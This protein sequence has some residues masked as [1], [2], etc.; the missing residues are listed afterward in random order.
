MQ[1]FKSDYMEGAHPL[2]L[3]RLC[4][5]NMEKTSGYGTDEYCASARRKIAE[6]CGCP[7]AE[8]HFMVG[9]T[10]TNATVITA[11]LRPYEGVVAAETGH[12]NQHEAGAV[13]AGG[14]KVLA[15][16]HHEGKLDAAEVD[17]YVTAFY[18]DSS[19]DHMVSPGMVYISHPTEYGTLYT[20]DELKDLSAVCRKHKIPLFLDGARLGYGLTARDTDVTLKDIASLCDIFYIGGTK[21]GA[22]F[23]EAVVIPQPGLI[24]QFDTIVKQRGVLLAKGRLLGLQF[25]TLFTDGLYLKIARHAIDM[26]DRIVEG[27]K[28]NGYT[29]YIRPQ[30][31]QLFVQLENSLYEKLAQRIGFEVWEKRAD[32]TTVVRIATSWATR[33]EDVA[34]LLGELKNK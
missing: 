23:G 24:R 1:Y 25:D 18:Q 4:Q 26:A 27:L 33:E 8:V 32:G 11:L 14:H 3:E 19:W 30:S 34:E 28:A 16:P 31:N 2:I 29:F 12:I 17:R 5:T 21:V 20:L 7:Q 10:Q 9:G 15:L 22:L 13:E 6:A